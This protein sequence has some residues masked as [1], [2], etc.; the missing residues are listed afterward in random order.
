MTKLSFEKHKE[1][2]PDNTVLAG[3]R[4]SVA[5]NMYLPNTDPNSVDDVDLMGVFMA[6]VEHYIGITKT[7]ETVERFVGKYDV[8]SYEFLKFV[9]LLLKSNPNV[10]SLLWI[11]DNHYLKRHE[12]GQLLIDNRDLFVS[13]IAYKSFTGY[14]YG[15]LKKM[16]KFNCAGYMGKKRKELVKKFGMDTKNA[17]HCIRLLKMSTEFLTTGELNVF[18]QDAPM[19]LEIKTGKWILEQVKA[20]AKRLFILADEAYVRSKISDK[21]AYDKIE[22]IVKDIM[23]D[24]IKRNYN[25]QERF[26]RQIKTI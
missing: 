8:V 12:Y 24:Y 2:F 23:Y 15:Q 6:P 13:K 25:D 5:H 9:K 21:P 20:E 3:Y 1:L 14:A 16:E 18:R 17:A 26:N 4:G 19:L 22:K 7:K 11:R 10:M